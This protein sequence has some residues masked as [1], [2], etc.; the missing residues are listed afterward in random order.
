[1]EEVKKHN[2]E[3]DV[4]IIVNNR[5]YDCTEYLELHPGGID[6]ITINAGDD[7]T[8]DFVAIHSLK[9]TKMLEKYYIGDLDLSS[10]TADKK[11]EEDE[12]M[13]EESVQEEEEEEEE[14]EESVD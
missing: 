14:D 11:E 2:T 1:M 8:E 3:E 9:A 7:A 12:S 5:V 4:W 6:S 13:A 10:V